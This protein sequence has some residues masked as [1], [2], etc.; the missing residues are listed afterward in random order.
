MC[1]V[2]GECA[3]SFSVALLPTAAIARFHRRTPT[4]VAVLH[5]R[6]RYCVAAVV[7]CL[8]GWLDGGSPLLCVVLCC[9]VLCCA[10][11][12]CAVLCCGDGVVWWCGGCAQAIVCFIWTL[13]PCRRRCPSTMTCPAM[14][15]PHHTLGL[16][17]LCPS[18]LHPTHC[19]RGL[20]PSPLTPFVLLCRLCA[21]VWCGVVWCVLQCTSYHCTSVHSLDVSSIDPSLALA[22]YCRDRTDFD[23]FWAHAKLVRAA[24]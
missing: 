2:L 24:V 1:C 20:C 6:A 4:A 8:V 18:P 7:W 14:Y 17:C 15:A 10:V 12:C 5:R 21:V 3:D 9:A 13:T 19:L 16:R 23:R 22:F 11:L